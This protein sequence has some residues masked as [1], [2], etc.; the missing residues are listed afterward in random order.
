MARARAQLDGVYKNK[1]ELERKIVELKQRNPT[2]KLALRLNNMELDGILMEKQMRAC[3]AK[4]YAIY[5]EMLR[6]VVSAADVVCVRSNE[7]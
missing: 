5:M 7:R 6:D 3:G 1:C 4:A 2:G